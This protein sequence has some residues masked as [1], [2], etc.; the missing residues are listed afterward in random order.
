MEEVH[1]QRIAGDVDD[2]VPKPPRI[3]G[4]APQPVPDEDE[5]TGRNDRDKEKDTQGDYVHGHVRSDEQEQTGLEE[6]MSHRRG[7]DPGTTE[8][9]ALVD[10]PRT[11]GDG[12]SEA[13]VFDDK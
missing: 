9:M 10:Q 8:G 3:E 6:E 11:Y 7:D 12:Q 2:R 4:E 5:D 1:L 13:A